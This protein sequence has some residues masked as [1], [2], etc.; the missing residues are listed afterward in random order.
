MGFDVENFGLGLLAGW[1]TAYGVYR[2]R[3]LISS[4]I[5]SVNQQA[6]S[7]QS[8]ATQSSDSRYINNIVR[9]AQRNHIATTAANLTDILIEPRFLTAPPLAAPVEDIVTHSIFHVVPH[10]PDMPI[11]Q[12]PYNVHTLS[13]DELSTG[14]RA[15][16][17][18]ATP[19]SG[20]TT[21]LMAIMLR[22]LGQAHFKKPVDRVQ[23]KL[24]A[25]EAA[26]DDKKRAVR[27]KERVLLEQRAKERLAEERGM[28]LDTQNE[29]GIP[30][31]NRLMPVYVH[32]SDI[33]A[34]EATFGKE[35][36]PAEPLVRAVQRQLG[37]VAASVTP[38]NLY[39]RLNSGQALLLIDGYDELAPQEQDAQTEWLKAFITTYRQN[40][41]IITG[42]P[43]QHGVL[44]Q[45]IG[46][47]P[48]FL[49]PWSDVDR[50][51]A[52]DNW[53]AVWS[54]TGGRRS[55]IQTP[56]KETIQLAKTNNRL[57]T[58]LD[59]T[60]KI[61]AQFSGLGE[62][63]HFG[64]WV[65]AL[66]KRYLP[67]DL[68]DE[69]VTKYLITAAALQLDEGYI[70]RARLTTI[71]DAIAPPTEASEIA[72]NIAPVEPEISNP[73]AELVAE[74]PEAKPEAKPQEKKVE[75]KATPTDKFV[76]TLYKTG[77]LIRYKGGRYR[78]RH[79]NIAAYL[80]SQ[81]LYDADEAILTEKM[82][83]PAWRQA[84]TYS[85][86][87][88][89][90]NH[91]VDTRMS[92]PTDIIQSNIMEI[93]HWLRYAS[94]DVE[95]RAPYINYLGKVFNAPNQYPL[96][97]ERA[98]AALLTTGDPSVEVIFEQATKG[99]VAQI[100]QLACLGMGVIGQPEGASAI[101]PLLKDGGKD[102]QLAAAL[103]LG[104][105]RTEEALTA[106][107]D[108]L[109]DGSESLRQAVA[110]TL[111]DIPVEGYPT[112]YD[113]IQDDEMIVRRAAVFGIKRL[114]SDWAVVAIY[115]AFLEDSQWYVRSAAQM[116]FQEMRY[117]TGNGP[118][119]YPPPEAITWL[120]EW[121]AKRQENIPP[122]EDASLIL[123][124]AIQEGEDIVRA[125]AARNVGQLGEAQ[126]AKVLYN[127]LRDKKSDVR[128][129]A[130]RS[131][132]DL[133]IQTGK[134]LPAPI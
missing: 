66:T 33:R 70:T 121:A 41:F 82:D 126:M 18:L 42:S 54:R 81:S 16:A 90:L 21:A 71:L 60:S 32:L 103:A 100:R 123:V 9:L 65:N 36:D 34:D 108:A 43:E 84:I 122:G 80:A 95:W 22:A 4:A 59:L 109:T 112:L 2:A 115:R 72:D 99:I 132:A 39:N 31:F 106:L 101:I 98:A 52:V 24:D 58:P 107:V 120:N 56:D 7:A 28:A 51:Q 55:S 35:I 91:F 116:A 46:L 15:L 119:G 75:K 86:S 8:Y 113:A 17:L 85:A 102:V 78:F 130:H 97:R 111:A 38:R 14:D 117:G 53:A 127:T 1:A 26:L 73:L 3:H 48:V 64:Y 44:T 12:A 125:L 104:A 134:L 96:L 87:H 68:S 10:I 11:L 92:N 67:T 131:L 37:R 25:E 76:A 29:T 128:D 57:L 133:Q 20:R 124:K 77:L 105:I 79:S 88:A 50:E 27:I 93:A 49:R 61:W 62:E 94:Q 6:S 110:E 129:A 47:T 23:Q 40:F 63:S 69:D 83:A 118:H 74:T 13:I 19:G 5:Q 45:E 30:L 89:P 114:K